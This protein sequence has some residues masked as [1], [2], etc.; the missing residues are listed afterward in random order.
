MA[1]AMQ[2]RRTN[3]RVVESA[4]GE[5]ARLAIGARTTVEDDIT[6]SHSVGLAKASDVAIA[7]C[8][9]QAKKK[10]EFFRNPSPYFRSPGIQ[11]HA[12]A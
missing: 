10:A 8:D 5:R 11:T 1:G 4:A 7:M 12:V 9:K 2:S 3:I 6:L